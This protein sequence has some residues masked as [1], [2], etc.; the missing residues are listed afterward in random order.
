LQ[1]LI[2]IANQRRVLRID[3]TLKPNKRSISG[4]RS[5]VFASCYFSVDEIFRS[6]FRSWFG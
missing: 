4:L 6:T 5:P 2:E 1:F 3:W